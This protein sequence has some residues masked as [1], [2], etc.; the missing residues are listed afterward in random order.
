MKTHKIFQT[1]TITLAVLMALVLGAYS[2]A[3]PGKLVNLEPHNAAV[4]GPLTVSDAIAIYIPASES[5][6]MTN[7]VAGLFTEPDSASEVV[8]W[9]MPGMSVGLLGRSANGAYFAIS[10]GVKT[11]KVVG[12]IEADNLI[13]ESTSTHMI[14]MAEVYQQ[15]DKDSEIV[16]MLT[17]GK[18]I[19]VLGTTPD[20]DW[21]AVASQ[22]GDRGLIGW[23][24]TSDL[25]TEPI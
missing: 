14:A 15:P 12:W 8:E 6:G 22:D 1:T 21:S 17:Y 20:G 25:Q 3:K 5:S 23:V 24:L 2:A 16:N 11:G 13:V 4:A 19:N 10:G 7:T 9:L 18:A